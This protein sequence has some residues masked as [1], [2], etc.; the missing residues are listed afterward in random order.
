MKFFFVFFFFTIT[1]TYILYP[2]FIW[3]LSFTKKSDF[4]KNVT[5]KKIS[6]IVAAHN[7]EKV[8]EE[9]LLNSLNI[10]YGE[11]DWELIIVSDG[12]KDDT[13]NILK[14]YSKMVDKLKVLAYQPRQGKSSALNKGVSECVGEILVFSDANVF[15]DE[16]AIKFL[17]NHFSEES[18]GAVCGK[19]SLKSSEK[20]EIE[21]ESLYMKFENW[22]Q[23]S[24]SNFYSMIG[25]DGALFAIRREL[26][27]AL[28]NNLI[29]DDFALSMEAILAGKKIVYA[30]NAI[31]TE[32][33]IP[34]VQNEF[35]RKSRIVFFFL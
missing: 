26:Y 9:K 2:I 4:I 21:G 30:K 16:N 25:T 6:V 28:E 32:I 3:I 13:E 15:L 8:I 5:K 11:L 31:A 23:T 24:E 12:S 22:I 10:N 35:K 20:D 19:V 33:V 17:I 34:S 18:V 29:L 27:R 7:E 14:K 1:W